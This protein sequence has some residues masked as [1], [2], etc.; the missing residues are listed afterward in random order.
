MVSDFRDAYRKQIPVTLQERAKREGG[1]TIYLSG[2]GFR[3]WGYLL[4]YVDQQ[5]ENHYPKSQINGYAV[6]EIDSRARI[7]KRLLAKHILSFVFLTGDERTGPSSRVSS[8]STDGSYPSR[9]QRS[10]LLPGRRTRRDTF[11]RIVANV[12]AQDPLEVATLRFAAESVT[13]LQALLYNSIP[14]SSR[15]D[16]IMFPAAI[17]NHDITA[18]ANTL[19]VHGVGDRRVLI[20][21][22]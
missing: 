13:D 12:R 11:P 2:G 16:S 1:Y 7:W 21:S 10:S 17:S 19:Y 3:G 20:I 9:Y 18:F 14:R 5:D 4:L 8:E 6:V 15:N 22:S